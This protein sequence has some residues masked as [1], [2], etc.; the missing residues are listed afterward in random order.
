[1]NL[2][3]PSQCVEQTSLHVLQILIHNGSGE[4]GEIVTDISNILKRFTPPSPLLYPQYPL[5]T[6]LGVPQKQSGPYTERHI[7]NLPELKLRSVGRYPV[8]SL[9]LQKGFIRKYI[10]LL[11]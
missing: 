8:A 7:F 11:T 3:F 1:M 10:I 4:N 6:R 5:D 9:R 2:E